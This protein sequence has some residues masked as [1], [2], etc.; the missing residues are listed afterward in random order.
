MA[1][2]RLGSQIAA[3]T[4]MYLDL[5]PRDSL[6]ARSVGMILPLAERAFGNRAQLL[7]AQLAETPPTSTKPDRSWH[8]DLPVDSVSPLSIT[9]IF[10]LDAVCDAGNTFVLPAGS[11]P[12]AS[13]ELPD[14]REVAI[15]AAP[16]G[17]LVFSGSIWHSGSAPSAGFRRRTLVLQFGYWWIKQQPLQQVETGAI[18]ETVFGTRS[19]PGDLYITDR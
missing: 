13:L 18:E 7:R 1:H 9:A 19:P 12:P 11:C 5:D 16:G 8:R 14:D 15:R 3:A 10:Y 17:C 6:L 4:V 2:S